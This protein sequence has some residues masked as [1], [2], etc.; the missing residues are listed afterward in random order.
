MGWQMACFANGDLLLV[1]ETY[2]SDFPATPGAF[3]TTY[4]N[5]S[6]GFFGRLS[7]DGSTLL[8]ASFLGSNGRDVCR[9]AAVDAEGNIYIVGVTSSQDFPVTPDAAFPELTGYNNDA[10]LVKFDPT[11]TRLLY[12]TYLGGTAGDKARSIALLGNDLVC[13]TGYTESNDFPVTANAYDP[14]W[15]GNWDLF[16]AC[17][18]LS[19]GVLIQATYVGGPFKEEP[20]DMAA[21]AN[22]D[23]VITGY[24]YS[25]SFPATPDSFDP[26]HNGA[27][28]GF[29]LKFDPIASEVVYGTFLGGSEDDGIL[30]FIVE[31]DGSVLCTGYTMSQDFPVTA[32]AF[33]T[34]LGGSRDAFVAKLINDGSGMAFGTFLGGSSGDTGEGILEGPLGNVYVAGHTY[35]DNFPIVGSAPFSQH[36]GNADVFVGV[37]DVSASRL[38]ASTYVGGCNL[39]TVHGFTMP[40]PG[41]VAVTGVSWSSDFPTTGGAFCPEFC[42]DR[43]AFAVSLSFTDASAGLSN[44][45]GSPPGA[46]CRLWT[47][48]P[49]GTPGGP[50]FL[51]LDRQNHVRLDVIDIQG[52]IIAAS[53]G[54]VLSAGR[55]RLTLAPLATWSASVSGVYLVRADLGDQRMIRKLIVA[56]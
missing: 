36:S 31:A 19:T 5:I 4:A 22:G 23:V 12:G 45:L 28:D 6:E 3:D 2:S 52:R 1:G 10:Y 37:L 54:G 51:E 25:A 35:S 17:F 48:C 41:R 34:E 24:T 43:D 21:G 18:D 27:G 38:C 44:D 11:G 40:E 20:W 14:S 49:C 29:V 26:T 50:I 47:T 53:A 39:E 42:G 33:D 16:V 46:R 15:N 7:S 30:R 8:H 55:H 56:R 32:S 9:D 13:V